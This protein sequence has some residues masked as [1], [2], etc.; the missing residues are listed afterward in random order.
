MLLD[1]GRG[2][3]WAFGGGHTRS[4]A[5]ADVRLAI[6][7]MRTEYSVV[8]AVQKNGQLRNYRMY[9]ASLPG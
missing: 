5:T 2:V 7:S 4:P 8:R 6:V 9:N 3:C 1:L